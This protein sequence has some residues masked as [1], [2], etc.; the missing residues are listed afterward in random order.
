MTITLHR[1]G[2]FDSVS[3]NAVHLYLSVSRSIDGVH[4][5]NGDF[6]KSTFCDLN[7]YSVYARNASILDRSD[8]FAYIDL[9]VESTC[10]TS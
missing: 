9:A 8:I 4:N 10:R 5:F 7:D 2:I 3:I 6:L 1:S